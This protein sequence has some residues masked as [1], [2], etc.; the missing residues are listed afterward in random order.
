M[1][2]ACS[3]GLMLAGV[4]LLA[5]SLLQAGCVADSEGDDP[6]VPL[7]GEVE[8]GGALAAESE[9]IEL[10]P[11]QDVDLVPGSQ[12]GYH[13][14]VTLRLTGVEGRVTVER[15]ARQVETD[16]LILRAVPQ[17]FEVATD[18]KSDWWTWPAVIPSFMCPAPL[19]LTVY[20]SEVE[21][22]V[23]IYSEDDELLAEDHIRVVPRCPEG[24]EF[25]LSICDG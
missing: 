7:V 17:R 25:C 1:K 11:G 12:G 5:A 19:G 3:T 10:T 14:W 24:D 22:G 8:I 23:S 6:D 18:A 4:A 9:F 13:V 15:D 20:D 21:L 16:E 2:V